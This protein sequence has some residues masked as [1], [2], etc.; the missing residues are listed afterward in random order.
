MEYQPRLSPLSRLFE[1]RIELTNHLAL[2]TALIERVHE[3]P[4][5]DFCHNAREALALGAG[6]AY[7]KKDVVNQENNDVHVFLAFFATKP[8]NRYL[9]QMSVRRNQ[10]ALIKAVADKMNGHGQNTVDETVDPYE[11]EELEAFMDGY[12]ITSEYFAAQNRQRHL[13]SSELA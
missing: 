7:L 12:A 2:E 4:E 8:R 1:A 10:Q 6:Y 5:D 13:E 11:I 9:D 3:L